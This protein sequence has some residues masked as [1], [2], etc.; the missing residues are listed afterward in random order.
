MV[1]GP[2]QNESSSLSIPRV[3][4]LE[5]NPLYLGTKIEISA[6]QL[7][8]NKWLEMVGL[9]HA[10]GKE[11]GVVTSSFSGKL[12]T[13]KV[14]TG[15]EESIIRPSLPHG[16]KSLWPFTKYI[17]LVHTHP[18]PDTLNHLQTTLISDQD[19]R[20]FRESS[21]EVMVMV[22]RGGAHILLHTP[23]ADLE[24]PLPKFSLSNAALDKTA[25][26]ENTSQEA[27]KEL[28]NLLYPYGIRY[29]YSPALEA[30]N[31]HVQFTDV[32]TS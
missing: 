10:V 32:R 29:Y 17:A 16:L 8:A 26:G 1:T 24:K 12:I 2:D 14:F 9:T 5:K 11:R 25:K 19:I 6:E 13:S 21:F 3:N 23:M 4:L 18:M 7:A 15:S 27:R 20:A 22:D 28:A 30:V 31:G